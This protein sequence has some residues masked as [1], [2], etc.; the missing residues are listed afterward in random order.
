MPAL[1]IKIVFKVQHIQQLV[2]PPTTLT[3][4]IDLGYQYQRPHPR[5][6]LEYSPLF[7][8]KLD[9]T[10]PVLDDKPLEMSRNPSSENEEREKDVPTLDN[11]EIKDPNATAN[12]NEISEEGGPEPDALPLLNDVSGT[13]HQFFRKAMRN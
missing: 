10:I 13:Y 8:P 5:I 11:K 9:V 6:K 2:S 7:K 12:E 3:W 4:D 1:Q